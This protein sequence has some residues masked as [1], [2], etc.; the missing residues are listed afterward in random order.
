MT[1]TCRHTS[2]LS[3]CKQCQPKPIPV[4]HTAAPIIGWRTWH[5]IDKE[6][7]FYVDGVDKAG[8]YSLARGGYRWEDGINAA[9]CGGGG[10]SGEGETNHAVPDAYCTCG[11]YAWHNHDQVEATCA[12]GEITGLI[13]GAGRVIWG[14]RGWR[15]E[16]AR[17][18]AV[19]APIEVT[20]RMMREEYP[21]VKLTDSVEDL[22]KIAGH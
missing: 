20:Q 16:K 3:L 22:L 17:I 9:K 11:F 14:A 19:F 7:P 6:W 15:S 13:E 5:A 21:L 10:L 4:E 2:T 18:V 1:E 12:V 8:L